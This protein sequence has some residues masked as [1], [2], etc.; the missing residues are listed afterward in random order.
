[1]WDFACWRRRNNGGADRMIT[2]TAQLVWSLGIVWLSGGGVK[3]A[4]R[5]KQCGVSVIVSLW[6]GRMVVEFGVGGV[7]FAVLSRRCVWNPG[8]V[9]CW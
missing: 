5:R 1:M 9:H 8:V 4:L 6:G 7:D 2:V 3:L